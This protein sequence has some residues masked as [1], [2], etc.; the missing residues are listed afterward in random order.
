MPSHHI[1][2]RKLI[3]IFKLFLYLLQSREFIIANN[4]QI[5]EKFANKYGKFIK[6]N[7]PDLTTT[8]FKIL[9]GK[10]FF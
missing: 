5:I 9:T 6:H 1:F 10:V 7:F 2:K 4:P 8:E 3:T